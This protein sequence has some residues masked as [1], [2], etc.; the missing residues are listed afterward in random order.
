MI[1]FPLFF[2]SV[3]SLGFHPLPR[4]LLLLAPLPGDGGISCWRGAR[5]GEGV[6]SIF[7]DGCIYLFIDVFIY[8][9]LLCINALT[10]NR[11]D[12][13]SWCRTEISSE[14][15]VED[16]L[17]GAWLMVNKSQ[18]HNDPHR[19]SCSGWG[20]LGRAFEPLNIPLFNL[21][22]VEI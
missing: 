16:Y 18:S 15:V 11:R 9:L 1:F 21:L 2:H 22:S 4:F 12:R 3:L 10:V 14:V 6:H 13:R 20:G 7:I 19:R 17:T 5:E 8:L